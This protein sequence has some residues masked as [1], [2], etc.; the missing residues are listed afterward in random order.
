MRLHARRRG[1]AALP[2]LPIGENWGLPPPIPDDPDE[3]D[4][5]APDEL[6]DGYEYDA[7]DRQDSPDDF[8]PVLIPQHVAQ[9]PSTRALVRHYTDCYH[10]LRQRRRSL[11]RWLPRLNYLER[12]NEHLKDM[13]NNCTYLMHRR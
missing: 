13:L 9:H 1:R 7:L 4:P 2:P 10:A 8:P 11:E 3:G 6:N 12:E 5:D